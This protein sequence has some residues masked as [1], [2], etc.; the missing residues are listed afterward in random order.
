M[1][2]LEKLVLILYSFFVLIISSIICLI[3]FRVI[4]IDNINECM[5]LL[6]E[7]ISLSI[8]VLG[9]SIICILLSIK[10]I[11]FRNHK[12]IK[13]SNTT[14]ILLENDSGRLLISKRAIEN[15]VKNVIND[16]VVY[17]PETK[18][19]VDI[20]PANNLSI[21]VSILLDKSIK[22]R[23]FTID[24]QTKIKDKIK[25]NF[26]L[27]VKQVNIKIDSIEKEN[28]KKEVIDKTNKKLE[29]Q[30]DVIEANQSTAD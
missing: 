6:L 15:A 13:K 29:I 20:D 25:E 24:L 7:D 14:D 27:D 5:N 4:S 30:K 21:Y 12:K 19:I 22:V 11:F 28:D 3:I 9:I 26:D 1:K 2:V 23:E 8:I 10:C 16:G 18:V 17:N